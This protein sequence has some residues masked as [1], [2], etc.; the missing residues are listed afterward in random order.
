MPRW[1]S[2]PNG[3]NKSGPV[4]MVPAGLFVSFEAEASH[5]EG[6]HMRV[7]FVNG[8]VAY[9][10]SKHDTRVIV[11]RMVRELGLKRRD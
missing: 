11:D 9:P 10:N 2:Q 8:D 4:G 5:K 6:L 1:L 7:I 3:W